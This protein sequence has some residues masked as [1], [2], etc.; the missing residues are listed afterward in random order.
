[1]G[2]YDIA[3]EHY[4]RFRDLI[5]KKEAKEYKLDL[6]IEQCSR[7]IVEGSV[8]EAE[9]PI[10]A[11]VNKIEGMSDTADVQYPVEEALEAESQPGIIGAEP[12]QTKD[13][14]NSIAR[15]GLEYQFSADSLRRVVSKYRANLKSLS[16]EDRASFNKLI[17][18]LES[19]IFQ[20]Q[21]MADLKFAEAASYNRVL[22]DGESADLRI[23]NSSPEDD[24]IQDAKNEDKVLDIDLIDVIKIAEEVIPEPEPVYSIFGTEFKTPDMIPVNDTL[25]EGLYYRI[26]TAAFR[27]PIKA[28][29]FKTLGPVYGIK[30]SASEITYYFIGLFRRKADAD[31][32]LVNVRIEGFKDA[33]VVAVF[34]S[35]R[36]SLERSA[37]LEKDWADISLFKTDPFLKVKDADK[38]QTL[39]FWVEADRSEKQFKEESLETLK[40]VAGKRELSIKQNENEEFVCLIG[41]FLTFESAQA[42]A[43]L[44]F[45]NGLKEARVAAY[46]GDREIPLKTARELFDHNYKK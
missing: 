33:F 46:I 2:E 13:D 1:D 3:I 19:E 44:L 9:A 15:L 36:I 23:E 37:V 43:D 17:L 39:V 31:K 45:R 30:A 6:L 18:D 21:S 34:E 24:T 38:A 27:N 5:R 42:Y 29:Y 32:A 35:K 8:P 20:S 12:E 40:L 26:Q 28:T 11:A 22:Y 4:D 14:Y 16:G 41:K 7:A 25:P 10:K